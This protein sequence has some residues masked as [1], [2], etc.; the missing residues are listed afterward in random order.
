MFFIMALP[1]LHKWFCSP[2]HKGHQSCRYEISL[3]SIC[4]KVD[5]IQNNF[6]EMFLIML[7]IK[8]AQMGPLNQNKR[9]ARALDKKYLQTTPG[10]LV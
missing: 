3:N 8:I 2:E 9:A 4:S 5:Q 6:T 7:S 10:P 1:I